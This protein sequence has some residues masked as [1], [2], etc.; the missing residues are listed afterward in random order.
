MMTPKT[1]TTE[2]QRAV[3]KTYTQMM[4]AVA[5]VTTR[6]HRH[7]ADHGLTISQ[8][9]VLE[10]LYHQGSLCQRDIGQKILKTSG[11][12][13]TVIDNLEKRELVLRVKDLADRRR[14]S[15]GLTPAGFNLIDTIFP[16]HAE[17]AEQVFTIMDPGELLTLGSLLKKVGKANAGSPAVI[18]GRTT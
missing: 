13:T 4:R 14:I 12:M 5:A 8:F 9:G 3:L 18:D 11:N 17:I 6:M 7:L 16:T 1:P 2:H 15:V 10:A